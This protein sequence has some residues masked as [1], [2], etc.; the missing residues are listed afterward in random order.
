MKAQYGKMEEIIRRYRGGLMRTETIKAYEE[1]NKK[2]MEDIIMKMEA[3]LDLKNHV[4]SAMKIGDLKKIIKNQDALAEEEKLK[5]ININKCKDYD[6]F[7]RI[8]SERVEEFDAE[9][10]NRHVRGEI[11]RIQNRQRLAKRSELNWVDMDA[12]GIG[13]YDKETESFASGNF[14]GMLN[15][16]AS[17]GEEWRRM[18]KEFQENPRDVHTMPETGYEIE[19][20]HVASDGEKVTIMQAKKKPFKVIS[21]PMVLNESKLS[22]MVALYRNVKH[23]V[24]FKENPDSEME[25]WLGIFKLL[26]VRG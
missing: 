10:D 12:K 21:T 26:R 6:T 15:Y 2:T 16:R 11:C 3:F 9:R 20:F 25:Y 13:E 19:W 24:K 4:I 8:A 22:L 18:L 14:L 5:Y 23:G 7:I 1:A 17:G